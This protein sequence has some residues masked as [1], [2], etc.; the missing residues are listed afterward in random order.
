MAALAAP[1]PTDEGL[2]WAK[3]RHD[4]WCLAYVDPG[5]E[6][7]TIFVVDG[8]HRD[9]YDFDELPAG[10]VKAW[11]GPF[12]CP[13]GDFGSQTVVAAEEDH[14]RAKRN[15]E[16]I[17]IVHVDYRHCSGEKHGASI[18]S[19]ATMPREK[20]DEYVK[21]EAKAFEEEAAQC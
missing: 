6:Q 14:Q 2:Y 8:K 10:L 1:L 15:K 18:T 20:A 17:V 4:E 13:G 3:T 11:Y 5:N 19:V 16:A 9:V 21:R 7:V 12:A